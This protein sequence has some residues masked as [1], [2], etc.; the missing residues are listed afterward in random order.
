MNMLIVA[1][2]D[3]LIAIQNGAVPSSSQ[4]GFKPYRA[5]NLLNILQVAAN[6]AALSR[7]FG[8]KNIL[9]PD[10]AGQERAHI[11]HTSYVPN[12]G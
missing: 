7:S 3:D 9:H 1:E 2:N 8:V 6:H 4:F 11:A 12:S 10:I 5:N